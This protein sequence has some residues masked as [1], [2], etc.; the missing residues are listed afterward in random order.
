V[1]LVRYLVF[2]V[3][4]A[5]LLLVLSYMLNE[6]I[7]VTQPG[8]TGLIERWISRAT[9]DKYELGGTVRD[10]EG[11]PIPFAIVEVVYLD[12]RLSTRSR[13]DGQFRLVG[14][15]KTCE[16]KAEVVSVF[17]SAEDFREK[18][19]VLEF[20]TSKLEIVLDRADF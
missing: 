17:V 18:R 13:G 7:T 9:C 19:R 2:A 10:A 12:R 1:I 5:A 20:G 8:S 14:D 11:A 4:G 15:A 16:E 3:V 6:A